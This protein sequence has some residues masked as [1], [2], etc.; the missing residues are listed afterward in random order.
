MTFTKNLCV[1]WDTSRGL[2]IFQDKYII[3]TVSSESP[4]VKKRNGNYI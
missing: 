1:Q 3:I 4:G 2:V